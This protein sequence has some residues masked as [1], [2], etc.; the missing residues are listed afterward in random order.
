VHSFSS[1][2]A[3]PFLVIS[4]NCEHPDAVLRTFNVVLD[5]IRQVDPNA[6]IPYFAKDGTISVVWDTCPIY[7]TVGYD[8]AIQVVFQQLQ[9]AIRTGSDAKMIAFNKGF[10]ASYEK[11]LANPGADSA[12]WGDATARYDGE[13]LCFDPRV[14]LIDPV[15]FG[16]TP[17]MDVKWATL[18]KMEDEMLLKI[19]MGEEPV[20]S[21]D[22]FV[23]DWNSLGGSQITDE[24]K[25]TIASK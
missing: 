20:D 5:A 25:Q 8:R 21:F 19:I 15:F 4:K 24:V 2:P 12:A 23:T 11:N 18:K 13:Q 16:T 14:K 7:I 3:D 17:T 22:K 1:D 6:N 9:E 10:Y